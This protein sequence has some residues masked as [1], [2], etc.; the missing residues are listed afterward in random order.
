M[1]V[2]NQLLA[3]LLVCLAANLAATCSSAAQSPSQPDTTDDQQLPFKYTANLYSHKF[4]RPRCPFAR[5][6]TVSRRLRFHFRYQAIAQGYHPCRYCL[7]AI[8]TTVRATI[9]LPDEDK[10][11]VEQKPTDSATAA[12][13]DTEQGKPANISSP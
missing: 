8:W 4:H 3:Y 11:S 5:A 12:A 2:S 9:R 10:K 7:P 6:M 1:T 13:L